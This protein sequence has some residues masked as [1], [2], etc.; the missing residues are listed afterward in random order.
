MIPPLSLSLLISLLAGPPALAPGRYA[1]ESAAG[2]VWVWLKAD[3]SARFGGA[4]Y[5]WRIDDAI[6]HLEGATP[7][8]LTIT[9]AAGRP[10]LD[11]PPFERVCLRPA[12]LAEP[13]PPPP[14]RRPPALVG[15][16]RHSASGGTLDL[17]LD[18]AGRYVMTQAATGDAAARTTGAWHAD[19]AA[20][21]LTPDGGAAL[22]YRVRRAGDS[23]LVDGGDLPMRVVFRRVDAA[24]PR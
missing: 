1:G 15:G 23:L 17:L 13:T 12:P 22:R 3:G 20:L 19:D 2:L 9:E 18:A 8:A 10:C 16:W 11:G 4:D 5:R 7:L 24:A 21:V 6:L 14:R